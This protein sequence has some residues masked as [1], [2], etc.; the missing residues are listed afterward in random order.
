MLL[1]TTYDK[2]YTKDYLLPVGN[3]RELSEGASRA[4]AVVVT[5]CPVDIST[6]DKEYFAERMQLS[7]T[8]SYFLVR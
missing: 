7:S 1:L 6:A 2:P 4:D 8:R 3:L 5:K